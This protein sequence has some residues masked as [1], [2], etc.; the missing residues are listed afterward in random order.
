MGEALHVD[1]QVTLRALFNTVI[2][3]DAWPGG[4]EGVC[5]F[6]CSSMVPTSWV[7]LRFRSQLLSS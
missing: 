7:G 6:C 2:P 5:I 3:A 1:Q 4:W